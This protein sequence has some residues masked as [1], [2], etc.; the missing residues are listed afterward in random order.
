MK[1]FAHSH[2]QIE[3]PV[4]ATDFLSEAIMKIK[5]T[6]SINTGDHIVLNYND[7]SYLPGEGGFHPV[8]IQLQMSKDDNDECIALLVYVTSFCYS[9][10]GDFSELVKCCDYDFENGYSTHSILNGLFT[11]TDKVET[12]EAQ[13]NFDLFI[14]NFIAYVNMGSFK[15]KFESF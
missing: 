6:N 8:E 11:Q 5:E 15:L 4:V 9:N 7:E 13:E 10:E 2:Q 14:K 1:I 3:L 12:K